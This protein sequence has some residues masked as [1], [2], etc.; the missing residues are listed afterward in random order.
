M[1]EQVHGYYVLGVSDGSWL[2]SLD[3]NANAVLGRVYP[4]GNWWVA[5]RVQP[6]LSELFPDIETLSGEE[7]KL[8]EAEAVRRADA[9]RDGPNVA[10]WATSRDDAL[11]LF[12]APVSESE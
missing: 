6:P 10:G 5:L 9:Y 12:G 7:M 3:E 1:T 2:A 11:A 4:V 8:L